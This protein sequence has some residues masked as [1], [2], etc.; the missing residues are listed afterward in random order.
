MRI[1]TLIAAFAVFLTGLA[2][3]QS[4]TG[5]PAGADE[6]LWMDGRS[7]VDF[8]AASGL[9]LTPPATLE[10]WV[11]ATWEQVPD[12]DPCVLSL[13]GENG[14]VWA[15]HVQADRKAIGLFTPQGYATVPI[16]LDDGRL[17][18]VALVATSAQF[19]EFVVDGEP[20][21]ALPL[22]P[23]GEVAALFHIGSLDGEQAPFK[24]VL[25]RL[26]VWDGA[27]DGTEDSVSLIA[28]ST[29]ADG[30]FALEVYGE[31]DT[32][33]ELAA[34]AVAMSAIDDDQPLSSL[35]DL[36]VADDTTSGT[37]P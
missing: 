6:A 15:V 17:H 20:A 25:A 37:T 9:A 31:P 8:P 7:G 36:S 29:V 10:F 12:F 28:Q 3:G 2:F 27:A 24:G 14:V 34:A 30:N 19:T 1:E 5:E 21:G 11:A 32:D 23:S 16:R 22:G 26:R 13:E 35:D 18:S 4:A 33:A